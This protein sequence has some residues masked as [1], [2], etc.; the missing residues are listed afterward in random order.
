LDVERKEQGEY[1]GNVIGIDLGW[2]AFY[3]DQNGNSVECPKFLRRS[4]RRLKQH[5]RRLSQY[6]EEYTTSLAL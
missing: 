3:T 1:T 6:R 2:K 4:E 5:Q